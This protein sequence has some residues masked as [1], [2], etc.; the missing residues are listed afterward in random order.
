MRGPEGRACLSDLEAAKPPKWK[1]RAQR[2][3]SNR[4]EREAYLPPSPVCELRAEPS[5]RIVKWRN[6]RGGERSAFSFGSLFC[7][8]VRWRSRR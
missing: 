1:E 7:T 5:L 2:W 3:R 4:T 8:A 6:H